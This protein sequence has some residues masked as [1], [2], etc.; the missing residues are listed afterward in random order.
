[1]VYTHISATQSIPIYT[2]HTH[3]FNHIHKHTHTHI[4]IY[5]HMA[6]MAIYS[7]SLHVYI[8]RPPVLIFLALISCASNIHLSTADGFESS[9]PKIQQSHYHSYWDCWDFLTLIVLDHFEHKQGCII[10]KSNRTKNA[11]F[12]ILSGPSLV[13]V[14][15]WDPSPMCSLFTFRSP[16]SKAGWLEVGA[17]GPPAA[18]HSKL[19]SNQEERPTGTEFR[20]AHAFRTIACFT[21]LYYI[22]LIVTYNL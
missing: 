5:I 4:Y 15:P 18:R 19:A 10:L 16:G 2:K 21:H 7:V 12:L 14:E 6:Y 3:M 8:L 9:R 22:Q 17:A 20:H 13:S 11:L 1:M